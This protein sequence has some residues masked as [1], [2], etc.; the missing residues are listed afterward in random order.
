M[1]YNELKQRGTADFPIEYHYIDKN[2]T[3]YEMSAHWHTEMEIIRI[4]R[5]KLK[6]RLNNCEYEAETG[7][8]IFVNPETIHGAIPENCV[9]ECIIFH[10]DFL[11]T[12]TYS[13]KFFVESILNREFV[14]RDFNKYTE[15]NFIVS[16]N[17]VFEAMK[18]K[19]SGYKFRVI[20][21]LYEML[22]VV[23]DNH[24]Y[25]NVTGDSEISDSRNIPKLK[26]VLSFLR[27]NYDCQ[28]SLENIAKA[29]DMSPK[30]FCYFFKEKT[31][32]TPL[33]YLNG[34][35]IEKASQ[36]L[37]SSDQSVTEIAFSCGFN[38]LSYFIKTFKTLKGVS[39]TRF[40]KTEH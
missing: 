38:D 19:S 20:G 36:K 6:I 15:N 11:D 10:I 23:V 5:G 32:K 25:T 39:P 21:A 26:K 35:R 29:A 31:G 22:G 4:L 1:I 3:R 2:H 8:I 30:Y 37:L 18:H 17:A 9:Y 33:Q 24:L 28:L 27:D 14:I 7:D 12:A 34:F 40:R 16:V 13:C